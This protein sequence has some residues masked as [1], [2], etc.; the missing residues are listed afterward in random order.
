MKCRLCGRSSVGHGVLISSSH[1]IYAT[2][3]CGICYFFKPLTKLIF[4]SR[5][6]NEADR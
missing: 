2:Y 1:K 6:Y 3:F 5:E 4:L